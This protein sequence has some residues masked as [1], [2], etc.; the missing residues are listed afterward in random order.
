MQFTSDVPVTVSARPDSRFVTMDHH[1]KC[2]T[3]LLSPGP[4]ISRLALALLSIGALKSG[5]RPTQRFESGQR[6]TQL[7]SP[8]GCCILRFV[9]G[10]GVDSQARLRALRRQG[11]RR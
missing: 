3:P 10:T 4:P 8:D 6:P 7:A 9:K 11:I 5:Q 1:G 2:V